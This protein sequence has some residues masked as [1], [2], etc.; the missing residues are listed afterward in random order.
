MTDAPP[1]IPPAATD[2]NTI[3][4]L[5]YLTFIP[6]IIFL[7]SAPYNTKPIVKFHAWQEIGLSVIWLGL[8][9]VHMVLTMLTLFVFPVAA[10]LGIVFF[11]LWIALFVIWLIAMI[12]AFQGKRFNIPVLSDFAAKQAGL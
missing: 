3:C 9:I 7:V 12:Q 1:N 6:A 5:A 11:L 4:G 2:E 8:W 10:A